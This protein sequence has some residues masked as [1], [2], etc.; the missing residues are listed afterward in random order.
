MINFDRVLLAVWPSWIF[1]VADPEER[2]VAIPVVSVAVNAVLYG[3]IGWL[4]WFGLYRHRAMLG[5]AIGV[6]LLGWYFLFN[7]Y[8]GG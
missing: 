6:V 1:F 8:A 3:A 5:V 4:V 2:S 7:W